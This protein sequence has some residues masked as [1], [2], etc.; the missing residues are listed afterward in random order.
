MIVSELKMSVGQ[1]AVYRSTVFGFI[2]PKGP[3]QIFVAAAGPGVDSIETL[4]SARLSNS[5]SISHSFP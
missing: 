1:F 3:A 5:V 4:P 2:S